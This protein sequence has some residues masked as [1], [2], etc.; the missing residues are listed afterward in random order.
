MREVLYGDMQYS[1]INVWHFKRG[2]GN[3]RDIPDITTKANVLGKF[4]HGTR[5]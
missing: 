2:R 4:E 5:C 3:L 1:S